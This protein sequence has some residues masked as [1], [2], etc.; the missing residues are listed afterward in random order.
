[1]PAV[2]GTLNAVITAGNDDVELASKWCRNYGAG[3]LN[4]LRASYIDCRDEGVIY[5]RMIVPHH[6]S[7]KGAASAPFFVP[8]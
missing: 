5:R 7:K 6:K 2:Y 4:L 3:L 1:M 8:E